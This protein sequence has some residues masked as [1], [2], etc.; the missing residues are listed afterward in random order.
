MNALLS[1]FLFL[2]NIF[3]VSP[4]TESCPDGWLDSLDLGC[5]YF[6]L[7]SESSTW[8]G[9]SVF[10]KGLHPNSS[11]IEIF[12]QEE[13]NLLSLIA[14]LELEITG[15]DAWWIGLE[16]IGREGEWMWQSSLTPVSYVSWADDRP[17][18]DPSN[19]D[20]CVYM[21]PSPV[22][23]GFVWTDTDCDYGDN[24]L[25]IA[26]L[27]QIQTFS[28]TTSTSTTST[29]TTISTTTTTTATG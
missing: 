3:S 28:S 5:L 26:P 22:E 9:A 2:V 17:N 14:N 24:L 19:R 20:D 21:S 4:S 6:G 13:N 16:D 29:T 11:L 8:L 12:S 27:C 15:A 1:S 10:C 25:I 7:G 23:P 18:S